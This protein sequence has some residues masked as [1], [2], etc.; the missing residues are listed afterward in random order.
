MVVALA[1]NPPAANPLARLAADLVVHRSNDI[2]SPRVSGATSQS[3]A[4]RM[5]GC[6]RC[7]DGRPAPGALTRPSSTTP[8]RTSRA[9]LDTLLTD[10]PAS[11]ATRRIPP[12]PIA[13]ASA[14]SRCRHCRSFSRGRILASLSA[15]DL[16]S[17]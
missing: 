3:N 12:Q 2:G 6:K 14:P 9:P 17:T 15:S 13:S 7:T 11:R 1:V 5:P 10:T 8:S 16:S 4:S